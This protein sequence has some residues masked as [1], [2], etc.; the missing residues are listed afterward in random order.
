MCGMV[1]HTRQVKVT[2]QNSHHVAGGKYVKA[3]SNAR[4]VEKAFSKSKSILYAVINKRHI[5]KYKE[6]ERDRR[7]GMRERR[8]KEVRKERKRE[9]E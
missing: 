3:P 8:K 9:K 7:N 4:T 1:K 2:I 6:N 5:I